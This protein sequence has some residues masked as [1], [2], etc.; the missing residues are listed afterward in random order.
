MFEEALLCSMACP[1][2][3]M[4]C[5]YIP[6]HHIF[7]VL[8][9]LQ[10]EAIPSFCIARRWT[11]QA[12]SAFPS[13]RYGEVY[14]WSDQMERYRQLRTVASEAFFRC[15]MTEESTLKVMKM[16]DNL[17]LEDDCSANCDN[18]EIQFGH[19]VRQSMRT[20]IESSEKVLDPELVVPKGAPTKRM[21]GFLEKRK[22]KCG[23]CRLTGHTIRTCPVYLRQV[24]LFVINLFIKLILFYSLK[25]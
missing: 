18:F 3:K 24:V 9:Y 25:L 10:L 20:N 7:A 23:F 8:S 17:M 15:S 1:C 16:L 11:M 13:D 21:R 4:E 2:R 6:C 19:V 5:Q 12:K 14:T 22:R